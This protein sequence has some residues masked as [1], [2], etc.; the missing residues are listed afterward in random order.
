MSISPEMEF[1][2]AGLINYLVARTSQLAP[3]RKLNRDLIMLLW[4]C[5]DP[6]IS[7][8]QKYLNSKQNLFIKFPFYADWHE[9]VEEDFI[10]RRYN[11][12]IIPDL[13]TF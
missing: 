3:R 13:F 6:L 8:G 12:V 11:G 5:S 4:S 1:T 9:R 7:N 2:R 10:N